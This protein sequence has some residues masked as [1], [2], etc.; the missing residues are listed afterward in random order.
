M[1]FGTL[2]ILVFQ[3]MFVLSTGPCCVRQYISVFFTLLVLRH[4]FVLLTRPTLVL[5]YSSYLFPSS[6]YLSC[7]LGPMVCTVHPCIYVISIPIF[8]RQ[9]SLLMSAPCNVHS[10]ISVLFILLV[11]QQMFVLMTGPCQ[12]RR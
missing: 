5:L 8:L 4:M 1:Y 3:Q 10:C 12:G 11:L 9:L 7:S 2:Q 6:I